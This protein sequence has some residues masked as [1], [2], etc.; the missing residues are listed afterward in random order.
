MSVARDLHRAAR[1]GDAE[2]VRRLLERGTDPNALVSLEGGYSQPC[3]FAAAT[4]GHLES[5]VRLFW[6]YGADLAG[7]RD[8]SGE[9]VLGLLGRMGKDEGAEFVHRLSQ[10]P[11]PAPPKDWRE[12]LARAIE[13]AAQEG[14]EGA[15][16]GTEEEALRGAE[17]RAEPPR[18]ERREE[19]FRDRREESTREEG[20]RRDDSLRQDRRERR[21]DSLVHDIRREGE[22]SFAQDR[23][24]EGEER[25]PSRARRDGLL[26]EL[27]ER[28]AAVAAERGALARQ[29]A[30]LAAEQLALVAQLQL[31]AR[32]H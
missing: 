5:V 21:E 15:T 12:L 17:R 20:L 10:Q 18:A 19:Q 26:G 8:S 14:G 16:E 2:E 11:R 24:R 23:R 29:D 27:A 4:N 3:F 22:D 30:A 32:L 31:L 1:N 7:T 6:E 9:N 13:S 28:L 25:E